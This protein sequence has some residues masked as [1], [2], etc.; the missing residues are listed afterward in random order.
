MYVSTIFKTF[1]ATDIL[2]PVKLITNSDRM[3]WRISAYGLIHCA[4]QKE[5]NA[6]AVSGVSI[7]VISN[8]RL[9]IFQRTQIRSICASAYQPSAITFEKAATLSDAPLLLFACILC[10][11]SLMA[12]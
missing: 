3:R 6:D 9:T 11:D 4:N 1:P 10:M 2:L 8:D 5:G 12:K 7:Q